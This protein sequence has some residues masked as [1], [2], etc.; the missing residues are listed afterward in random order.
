MQSS[1]N[2]NSEIDY[3]SLPYLIKVLRDYFVKIALISF[4]S[5]VLSVIYALSLDNYYISTAKF[6]PASNA[7]D[8]SVSM[9][10]LAGM[11]TGLG[12]NLGSSSGSRMDFALEIL[13]STDFFKT[14]YENEQ[15]LL[16]LSAIDEYDSIA[17]KLSFDKDVYDFDKS[18]WIEDG[19]SYTLTKKPS[20]LEAKHKFFSDHI[21]SEVDIETNFITISITHASPFVANEWLNYISA[22]IDEYIQIMEVEDIKQT[23]NYL[24]RQL[25]ESNS[26]EVRRALSNI[27][28]QQMKTLMLSEVSSGY[29]IKVIDSPSFPE[30]KSGPGRARIC[31][32]LTFL[33]SLLSYLF[34]LIWDLNKSRQFLI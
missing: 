34:I 20:L 30:Q 14:I 26:N 27:L 2:I 8:N 23:I 25:G 5:G 32:V 15:F 1:E 11:A 10:G 12:L 4:L 19:D 31:I 9:G 16:E 22:E 6:A 28:E 24:N 29:I 33:G 17:K 18:A 21:S 7:Q 3:L 13:N